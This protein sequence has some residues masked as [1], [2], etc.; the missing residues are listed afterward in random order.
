MKKINR[1]DFFKHAAVLSVSAFSLPAF[2]ESCGG[3]NKNPE[4]NDPCTDTSRLTATE[5]KTRE[6]FQYVG[7]STYPDK[8]CALCSYFIAPEGKVHCGTCQVVKGPINP[9]GYCNSFVKKQ[10]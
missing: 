3:N 4:A 6:T 1:K 5:L 7:S 2:L 8:D 9:K 10:A